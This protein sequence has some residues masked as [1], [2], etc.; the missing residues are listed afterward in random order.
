VRYRT[1]GWGATLKKALARVAQL[2]RKDAPGGGGAR[3][4]AREMT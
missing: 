3:A 4:I 2:S 1:A